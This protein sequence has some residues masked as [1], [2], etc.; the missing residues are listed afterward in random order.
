MTA[1]FL[2]S[3]GHSWEYLLSERY[4]GLNDLDF[5]S[6][7]L[8]LQGFCFASSLRTLPSALTTICIRIIPMFAI[9]II[10]NIL[11]LAGFSH[12]YCSKIFHW[13]LSYSKSPES[14]ED[15]SRNVGRSKKC[16]NLNGFCSSSN[17][18]L[19]Q[20]LPQVFADRFKHTYYNKYH[21]QLL[22]L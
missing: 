4:F 5:S 19:F 7:F 17:F 22:V 8:F 15:P 3:Q 1:S 6:N 13:S 9:T 10:I 21:R 14:Q 11:L 20:P 12:Q 2:K 18:Q 16:S